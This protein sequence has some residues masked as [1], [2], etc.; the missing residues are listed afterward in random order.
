MTPGRSQNRRSTNSTPSDPTS[1]STS[2]GV[3][4]STL[5][6]PGCDRRADATSVPKTTRTCTA[7][8]RGPEQCRFA[9]RLGSERHAADGVDDDLGD[10]VR[11]AVGVGP[12]GL[13]VALLVDLD[14]R[15]EEHRG[16]TVRHAVAVLVLRRRLDLARA[17]GSQVVAANP[18]T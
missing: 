1:S 10:L 17:A 15:S 6:P 16:A 9:G 8:G 4:S 18:Q 14:L 12:A 7:R 5:L 2:F 3:R 13:D 11:I